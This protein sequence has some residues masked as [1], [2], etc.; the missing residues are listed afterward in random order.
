MNPTGREAR[1]A[2]AVGVS[3]MREMNRAYPPDGW[4]FMLFLALLV[5]APIPLGSNRAWAWSLLELGVFTLSACWLAFYALGKVRFATVFRSAWWALALFGIWLGVVALQ[6]VP[7]PAALLERLSPAPAE[8]GAAWGAVNATISVDPESTRAFALKSLAYFLAFGLTLVLVNRRERLRVLT[9]VLVGSGLV[10]AVYASFIHL[11]GADFRVFYSVYAHSAYAVGTFINRNHL[12]GYLEMTLAVG[13]GA[14][15][16]TLRGGS[17]RNWRQRFRDWVGWAMSPRIVLRLMLVVMVI[18]LVM[19]RSRMGNAAFFTSMLIAGV[20]GLALSRHATRSTVILLAS[21]VV[22][23]IFVVGA[24]FGVEKVVQRIE[25]TPLMRS[26]KIGEQQSVEERVEPGLSALASLRGYRWF[27]SGGGTF[28]TVF[29]GYRVPEIVDFYDFAH[30]DYVQFLSEVGIVGVAIL[31]L[32]VLSTLFVALRTQ[33]E[34]EDPLSRGV[35]FS[36]TMGIVSLA[37][38]SWVDF[39]LQIPANALTFTVL[40]AMGWVAYSVER[41]RVREES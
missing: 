10:Q 38:H 4:I 17:P 13:I 21:L 25:Q 8:I 37:I 32:L 33:Y 29:P 20:A 41:Q 19:T 36:V 27:G 11:V 2:A 3:S 30:N 14:M 31:G 12:A 7:L 6:V 9:F 15:I 26:D 40:L 34:R 39:N 22:I 1:T 18:A 23:D 16:A 28:Y 35:A 5:W 24:W